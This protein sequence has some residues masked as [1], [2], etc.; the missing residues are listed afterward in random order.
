[1]LTARL[2]DPVALFRAYLVA[3]SQLLQE[4]TKSSIAR[5]NSG[6]SVSLGEVVG[7]ARNICGREIRNTQLSIEELEKPLTESLDVGE[8]F[9]YE[10][11]LAVA[12]GRMS[13]ELTLNDLCSDI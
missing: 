3:L 11:L 12:L 8:K 9:Y 10:L 4:H 6:D 7:L 1:M 2:L 5:R 13:S